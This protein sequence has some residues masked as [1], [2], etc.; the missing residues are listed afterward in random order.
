MS[1][2][3]GTV[4]EGFSLVGYQDACERTTADARAT[5]KREKRTGRPINTSALRRKD[6]ERDSGR[7][8]K[9]VQ[10]KFA[11]CVQAG[12]SNEP[13]RRRRGMEQSLAG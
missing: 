6:L 9:T 8:Q 10:R 2:K 1:G 3:R 4:L 13:E 5:V 12:S 7:L 11:R